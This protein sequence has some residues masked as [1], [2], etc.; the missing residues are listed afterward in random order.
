MKTFLICFVT[1]FLFESCNKDADTIN[2]LVGEWQLTKMYSVYPADNYVGDNA[3]SLSFNSNH[4]GLM[5]TYQ[6]GLVSFDKHFKYTWIP[7]NRTLSITYED[8]EP[9][10]FTI[11]KMDSDELI[12]TISDTTLEF[13]KR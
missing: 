6:A 1:I 13:Q 11:E 7:D 10:L 3:M 12:L 8:S 2:T 5:R 9:I 4:T